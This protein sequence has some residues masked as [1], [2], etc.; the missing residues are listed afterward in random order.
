MQLCGP[1]PYFKLVVGDRLREQEPPE[2]WVR[3]AKRG[4]FHLADLHLGDE[5]VV[6]VPVDL[7]ALKEEQKKG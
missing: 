2:Q 1:I 7:V 4:E 5:P 3:L 6:H